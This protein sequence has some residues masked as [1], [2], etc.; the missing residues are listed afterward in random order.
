MEFNFKHY[1]QA[2]SPIQQKLLGRSFFQTAFLSLAVMLSA[3][4]VHAERPAFSNFFHSMAADL[5][6]AVD[7]GLDQNICIGDAVQLEA[8]GANSYQWSP[9]IGLS[10][11]NCPNPLAS[12]SSTTI[13]YVMGDDGTVDSVQVAVF[14]PPTIDDVTVGNSTEC[15]LPTGS[16]LVEASGAG[17]LEYSI[18]GGNGWQDNGFFTAWPI[19]TYSIVVR[20]VGGAC[21]VNGGTVTIAEP[22]SPTILNVLSFGPTDCDLNNGSITVSTAGGI[23]PL[24]YSVDGGLTWQS[25]NNFTFL[26]SGTYNVKVRNNDGS[27]ELS[28]GNVILDSPGDEA[29]ITEIFLGHPTNCNETNG[30]ITIVA[31]NTN[32]SDLLYS[33]DGGQNYQ[34]SNNFPNL[35]EGIYH[36]TAVRD[37]STCFTSGGYVEL[38]SF[39]RATIYGT[40]TIEPTGCGSSN[41]NITILAFGP[42]LLEFSVNGG[43]T[44]QASNIF[45]GLSAGNYQIAVRNQGGTCQTDGGPVT[46]TGDAL[47]IINSVNANSPSACGLNDG[48]ISISASGTGI[49]EYSI[50]GGA[51]WSANPNFTGLANGSYNVMVRFQGTNCVVSNPSNPVQLSSPGD[52]PII[53][54]IAV[55]NTGNCGQNNG[56]ISV[57][58]SGTGTLLYSING[59][60]S[61][62]ANNSFFNLGA[63]NYSL[64]VLLA[65]SGCT[66]SANA[67]VAATPGCPDTLQ[68]TIPIAGSTNYCLNPSVL[69]IQG[70][71]TS[72]TIC[73]PGN[74][75]TVQASNLNNLCVNLTPANGF[76]GPSPDLICLVHCFNNS[77]S[78]CD[79][80]F[81][82]V[83]AQGQTSCDPVFPFDSVSVNYAGNPTHY[84]V[85]VPYYT[86]F[87]SDL[88]FEGQN[89]VDPFGCEF[90]PT[91]A[92]SYSFLPGGGFG[93]PYQLEYWKVNGVDLSGFFN[94][95]NALL[96]LMN[97]LD[98]S[99]NWQ[100]N[101]VGALIFGGNPLS[102]YGDMKINA[103]TGSPTILNP[104]FTFQPTGFTV[105]LTHLGIHLLTVTNPV[106]GCSDT[107][108][109]NAVVVPTV[110]ETIF[111][112]IDVNSHTDEICLDGSE[113]PGNTINNV[114]YC[115]TPSNGVAPLS[116]DTCVFYVPNF[117]FA[118]LDTFCILACDGG[119]PQFCDTTIFIIN[120]LPETDVITVNIPAGVSGLDTCLSSSIIELPGAITSSSICGI[121]SNQIDIHFTG[122]CLTI[123][124][125]NNF[126]GTS[127]ACVVFCSGAIC[128]TTNVIVNVEAPII[129]DDIFTQNPIVIE[130]SQDFGY[131]CVGVPPGDIVGYEVLLDGVPYSQSYIPCDF[132]P[133]YF[134]LY[135]TLPAGPYILNSWVVNNDVFTGQVASVQ[136]LVDSMNVWDPNGDWSNNTLSQAIQG[137]VP[138]NFYGNIVITPVG[139]SIQILSPDDLIQPFGSQITVTGPGSHDLIVTAPN[140]CA[141]TTVVILIQHQ[142]TTETLF[143][144]NVLNTSVNPICANTSELIG[145]FQAMNLCGL[146]SFGSIAIVGDTCVSYTP[147]LNFTGL[148]QFCLVVCD[149][150]Q[151]QV[152]DTF[153]VQIETLVPTDTVFIDAPGVDPFDECLDGSILQL[154]GI[155]DTAY[156]CGINA[157]EVSL[158]F[159]GNCVTIDLN[160]S[161]IGTT[162]ACV[163]HCTG[164]TPPV[165]D[166]TYLVISNDTTNN[167]CPEIFNPDE[168]TV[169][170]VNDTGEICLPVALMDI[171]NYEIT[172]D[173]VVYSGSLAGCDFDSAHIYNYNNVFGQG[174]LGPYS[175]NWNANGNTFTATN[176]ADMAA[177]VNLMNGWDPTGNWVLI[178]TSLTI[179]GTGQTGSYGVLTVTHIATGASVNIGVT[180]NEVPNGTQIF[181]LGEG[182]HTVILENTSDGCTDTLSINGVDAADVLNISTFEDVPSSVQCLDTTG[183]AGTF[184]AMTVCG[185]PQNGTFNIN[186]N[187]FVYVPFPGFTGSD[188]GCLVVCDDLG[189]CDTTFILINVIPICSAFNL[190]PDDT[191][192]IQVD[193]CADIAAY[194]VPVELDSIANY[195]VL[196]NG[197]PYAGGFVPCNG[198][199]TQIALDTGFHEII[200]FQT[201]TG[202]V[203]TLLANISCT[204]DSSGCGNGA[205]SPL[206]LLAED[207]DSL[208]EFC[209]EIPIFVITNFIVT[210]NGN[211]YLGLLN[212]CSSNSLYI[213]VKLDTGFHQLV[214]NDTVKGCTDTFDVS[215]L[216]FP[217]IDTTVDMT[218]PQGEELELCLED[219]GYETSI[220]DSIVVNCLPDGNASFDIDETTWCITVSGDLIGFDTGCFQ[221]YALDTFSNFNINVEVTQPCPD[222]LPDMLAVSIPCSQ[223]SG[224]VCLPLA[225]ADFQNK[226][227]LVDNVPYDRP[228]EPCGFDNLTAY[229]YSDL[230]S[231]GLLGPYSMLAWMVNG[232]SFTGNFDTP[233]ELVILMNALDAGG[234]WQ[235]VV[236]GGNTF[237]IGGNSANVY[238][239]MLVEQTVSGL[240]VTLSA[241]SSTVPNGF[242]VML[243]FGVHVL[244]LA[245]TLL[246]CGESVTT[247]VVCVSSE[248]F[249][250][251]VLIG[252]SDTL[253]LDLS[254]LAGTW[255]SVENICTG[256]GNASFEISDSCLVYTGVDIGLDSACIVLCDSFGV[257]DTTYVFITVINDNDSMIVAVDDNQTTGQG[258]VLAINVFQNDT[259]FSL[260]DFYIVNP[261]QHGM[262]VFLPDGSINYVPEAG[263][264]DD[265]V[266]DSFT[267][268]I[269]NE[270]NCDTATV[271]VTVECTG[272]EVF[273]AFSPNLDSKNDF[274]KITGLQNYP[275]HKLYVY[276]RWGNLVFE[277]SNYQSDWFG[278]WEG[279][280]LPD[281]TY[282]YVLDLGEGE[283]PLRGYVQLNR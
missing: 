78:Q 152:C 266:P 89:I 91:V 149:D 85:P 37:D 154:P 208:T 77:T 104:N 277:A 74:V 193:D 259:I 274:F 185:Q 76:S 21:P 19:G 234:N 227:I 215:I 27:C 128:D 66:V 196:D 178:S 71:V 232:T 41:G 36:I 197:F 86:L 131:F 214:F 159:T 109:I 216:C 9:A 23:S 263:F 162:T 138:S 217:L 168:I 45:N 114:G 16:I 120:V 129:C 251:T 156:I 111:L 47:P 143:F 243:E 15:A 7:A 95:A 121:N 6:F 53:N 1:E 29:N 203:D 276:N 28:H 165:C 33:I 132:T 272:L 245:D 30:S 56:Q 205:L 241:N 201:A 140:G 49:L 96:D 137:G 158:D 94:D 281:G 250:D 275:N 179:M 18:L 153:Y 264:C 101:P 83:T 106:D 70:T 273:N 170:V 126:A 265:D 225:V 283:K 38:R 174:S 81:L 262:A 189:N 124:P 39:N 271:F 103:T 240:Q 145:S 172:L 54:N 220:I 24:Q 248:I 97:M 25:Q 253:C 187:C 256:T 188:D 12:P 182:T 3:E 50:N 52:P 192:T 123:N 144:E 31:P 117:N 176:V 118:G 206:D 233:Q 237:I 87:G 218:V 122:N 65:G 44:W 278:T 155:I 116:N 160:N 212:P 80:T 252:Q 210:D 222:F 5:L 211:P 261:P 230:P 58:A 84:C 99:G 173:G 22:P 113:L 194:C 147:N 48:T 167:P 98:P 238:G 198:T 268:A 228:L 20:N 180:S 195:S 255:E 191:L 226:V 43:I 130:S 171:F 270:V 186:G 224:L 59:G 280:D 169:G 177:L 236:Q 67:T 68:V 102:T 61:F 142:V 64:V 88:V 90:D 17:P 200:F 213:S 108:I 244:T 34:T 40:S 163:I 166:T 105:S 183:L 239:G 107:L 258:Q 115:Q 134:Y 221:V 161:F 267:Y 10:C 2:K 82:S 100:I 46:L 223:D 110:T 79:T 93:G 204:I 257:C 8:T 55:T 269:C 249:T 282:F 11:T 92:Y 119:F 4:H 135:N 260:D 190:F 229:E 181:F 57:S 73:G 164:D 60:L 279:K 202:C 247:Q 207:C 127:L 32:G 235:V 75:A 141:D 150:H 51:A 14:S 69:D 42:S 184:V 219:Y 139:G 125:V 112:T 62:Q 231:S 175:V 254:E 72:T 209:V 151:P 63:G 242:G 199:F 35:P 146:P 13:Y 157:N 133:V 246:Q 148:D 26:T 136:A